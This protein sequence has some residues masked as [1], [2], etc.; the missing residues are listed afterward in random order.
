MKKFILMV[1]AMAATAVQA[2]AASPDS[3]FLNSTLKLGNTISHWSY[4]DLPLSTFISEGLGNGKWSYD[5]KL[6]E[7]IYRVP[8]K[9][10]SNKPV[11][12]DFAF[13]VVTWPTAGSELWHIYVGGKQLQDT[14]ELVK[15]IYFDLPSYQKHLVAVYKQWDALYESTGR[16][17]NEDEDD[18]DTAKQAKIENMS[19][20]SM[21]FS[22]E[23]S[24]TTGEGKKRIKTPI[25]SFPPQKIALKET[26]SGSDHA[27]VYDVPGGDCTLKI[28]VGENSSSREMP[29][30][31]QY[32][33]E[34]DSNCDKPKIP[35]NSDSYL[36]P[37]A[38]YSGPLYNVSRSREIAAAATKA[39][40]EEWK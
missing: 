28:T 32:R 13:G 19:S 17:H 29:L 10:G 35:H 24:M 3:T 34:C 2:L 15:Q 27:G 11:N 21:I 26:G 16:V 36:L 31:I 37:G 30:V 1:L 39:K 6:R 22:Y 12:F 7:W 5:K 40:K 23:T 33:G 4:V 18:F 8:R 38:G 14:S 25:C 20:D 9:L